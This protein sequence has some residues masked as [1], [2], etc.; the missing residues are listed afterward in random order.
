MSYFD[1]FKKRLT[2]SKE[3][4]DNFNLVADGTEDEIDE[5]YKIDFD[6]KGN[7]I[8]TPAKD[9]PKQPSS[10]DEEIPKLDKVEP[11]KTKKVAESGSDGDYEDNIDRKEKANKLY[12]A[13]KALF[14]QGKTKE[15]EAIRQQALKAAYGLGWDDN[16]LPPYT[17]KN[18]QQELDEDK[19]LDRQAFD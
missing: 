2:E 13:G 1:T 7:I 3:P 17:L 11:P 5:A 16:D 4:E 18:E 9:V 10:G 6:D 15:A 14:N 12:D 8:K 19:N